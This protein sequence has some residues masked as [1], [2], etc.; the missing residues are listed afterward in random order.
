V[1]RDSKNKK[2]VTPPKG[3]RGDVKER[4]PRPKSLNVAERDSSPSAQ[5]DMKKSETRVE[6]KPAKGRPMLTWVGKKPLRYAIAYPAQL[7]ETFR[8]ERSDER[9]SRSAVEAQDMG[10]LFHGD[11]K[12]VLAWLLANGYRGK[13]K[14]IY[15]DPPFDSGAD[16][17]RK[18][19]LR[20][21][22]TAGKLEAETYTLGEQIQY[23]DIWTFD[24]YL[25]FMY[26]RFLLLKE[27]LAEDGSIFVHCDHRRV[28][29]LRCLMDETFGP[30][31]FINEIIWQHQI[32]GG[33]Q[34][35]RFSKA[36]E[37]IIWYSRANS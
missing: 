2:S 8:A 10:L 5:S 22:T 20:G 32:M 11:N 13:V 37:T 23:T 12:D 34:D 18:V 30:D 14:L 7:V 35:R 17:L 19:S 25:Q 28:H 1:A 15:I 24:N 31:N 9:S 26:E 21:I 27:L 36:H 29:H 16:Y 3:H 4:S 6:I 33:A